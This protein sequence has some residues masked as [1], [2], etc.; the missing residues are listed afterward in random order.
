MTY[1]VESKIADVRSTATPRRRSRSGYGRKL[2]TRWE[3]YVDGRWRRVYVMQWSNAGSVYV[4][5]GGK[6]VFL[7]SIEPAD[8]LASRRGRE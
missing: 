2:P 6:E 5:V 4:I 1:L 3:L 7:G 8:L